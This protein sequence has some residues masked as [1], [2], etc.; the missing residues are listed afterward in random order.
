MRTYRAYER[1][2]VHINIFHINE[3]IMPSPVSSADSLL[4]GLGTG[5][6]HTLL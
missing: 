3:T 6:F 1:T 4:W 5:S 2:Y